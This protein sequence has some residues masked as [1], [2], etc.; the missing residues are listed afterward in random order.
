[1]VKHL[2]EERAQ[3]RNK[4]IDMDEEERIKKKGI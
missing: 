4:K 3:N 1:L 2:E